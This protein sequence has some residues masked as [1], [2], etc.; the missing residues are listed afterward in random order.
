MSAKQVYT[1]FWFQLLLSSFSGRQAFRTLQKGRGLQSEMKT[2]AG[3]SSGMAKRW[4]MGLIIQSRG[5]SLT[6]S[7]PQSDSSRHSV[8]QEYCLWV[9]HWPSHILHF[10]NYSPTLLISLLKGT[11]MVVTGPRYQRFTNNEPKSIYSCFAVELKYSNMYAIDCKWCHLI[12]LFS[13]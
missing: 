1:F 2:V 6:R 13:K 10:Q 7:Q 12:N 4:M 5:K 3:R 9:T 8:F 11:K